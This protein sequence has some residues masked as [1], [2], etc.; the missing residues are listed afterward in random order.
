MRSYKTNE[1]K[2]ALKIATLIDSVTL[3]LDQVGVELA[4]LSPATHYNRL[5]LIAEAAVEEQEKNIVRSQHN[6]LF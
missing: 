5:M 3:D 2:I 4:R 1:G 6:P